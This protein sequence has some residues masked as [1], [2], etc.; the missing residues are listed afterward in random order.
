MTSS[1]TCWIFD[2][3]NTLYPADGQFFAQIDKK[4]TRYIADFLRLDPIAARKIQKDYLHEYGTSLSGLMAVNNMNPDEFLHY[5]HDVDLSPLNPCN[6]MR[7]SIASLP[8]RKYI[9]T[10]GSYGHAENVATHLGLWDLMDGAYGIDNVGYI[11]KPNRQPYEDFCQA[12]D[13]NPTQAL[14]FEDSLKNLK[15]PK[16]MGMTT[17]YITPELP[18][19]APADWV[20]YM[21]DD[22]ASWLKT[23]TER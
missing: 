15:A 21:T 7:Q 4:M 13:V 12:F 3:D 14:M 8:G 19:T 16:E 6:R 20:D 11:P 2:L 23:Y 9:F 22:L 5:V 10:N 17:V 1:D 18:E